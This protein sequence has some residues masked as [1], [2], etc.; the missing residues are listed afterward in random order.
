[1]GLRLTIMALG[2][3]LPALRYQQQ[4]ALPS[5]AE[6]VVRPGPKR[7]KVRTPSLSLYQTLLLFT[8]PCC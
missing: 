1:M 7:I 4:N 5:F 6:E 3:A 2:F 8:G